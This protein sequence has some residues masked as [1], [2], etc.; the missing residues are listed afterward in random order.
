MEV[1]DGLFPSVVLH[2]QAE[3]MAVGRNGEFTP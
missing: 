2:V 3:K 1:S